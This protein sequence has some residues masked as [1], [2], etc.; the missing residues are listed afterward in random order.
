MEELLEEN[1]NVDAVHVAEERH[2]IA[3]L[4]Y[5]LRFVAGWRTSG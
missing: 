1:E 4:G 5:D 3:D 2:A